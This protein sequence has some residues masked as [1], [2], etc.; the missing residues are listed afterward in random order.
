MNRP[1][2]QAGNSNP[3]QVNLWDHPVIKA[4]QKRLDTFNIKLADYV[5]PNTLELKVPKK[6]KK[7]ANTLDGIEFICQNKILP[8]RE[9]AEIGRRD[10]TI[11]LDHANNAG[12]R[13]FAGQIRPE[14][15]AHLML[16][17]SFGQTD[18]LGFREI[19]YLTHRP[20]QI[21]QLVPGI[22]LSADGRQ[23][24]ARFGEL[25]PEIN[26]ESLHISLEGP[27]SA[28]ANTAQTSISKS[29]IHIDQKGF[30]F[31]DDDGVIYLSSEVLQHLGDELVLK[32]KLLGGASPLSF[33]FHIDHNSIERHEALTLD[34][35]LNSY[36]RAR[37]PRGVLGLELKFGKPDLQVYLRGSWGFDDKDLNPRRLDFTDYSKADLVKF[38]KGGFLPDTG[39]IG[40]R[41][42]FRGL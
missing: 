23:F 30:V 42:R 20:Q 4:I 19:R 21:R 13:A 2:G 22:L 7:E 16:Q 24:S 33:F 11:A 5:A 25:R 17:E 39:V 29:S 1:V 36:L 6:G 37:S 9:M 8:P 32:D 14:D 26:V 12:R 35:K 18:G 28:P 15:K 27:Q 34:P 3:G 38:V 40:V 41:V 10:F 31:A